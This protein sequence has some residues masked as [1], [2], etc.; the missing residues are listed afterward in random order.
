MSRFPT[1]GHLASWAGMCPGNHESAGKHHGG[2][3]RK[4][5]SWL[6]GALG[7]AGAG[8]ARSKDTYLQAR[9]RR[10]ASR[11]GKKR[12]LVAVGHSIL[13]AIWHMISNDTDYNDL[14]AAYFLTRTDPARQARRLLGQLHQLG[15]QAVITPVT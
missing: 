14:G 5:D 11:R 3:T 9:Y 12:A 15:Y 4:G 1:P 2:A 8:A 10:I 13:T 6:R 7:E